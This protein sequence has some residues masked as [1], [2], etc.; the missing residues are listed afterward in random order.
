MTNIHQKM[1]LSIMMLL[2]ILFIPA[3]ADNT[4]IPQFS[5]T[6]GVI[7]L[8][9]VYINNPTVSPDGRY[10]VANVNLVNID[11]R[12]QGKT[13]ILTS[14]LQF[15]WNLSYLWN[16]QG[17]IYLGQ[18]DVLNIDKTPGGPDF[19]FS[20]DSRYIG[21]RNDREVQLYT[22]ADFQL[23]RTQQVTL[24][25]TRFIHG[26]MHFSAWSPD[27]QLLAVLDGETV[28]VWDLAQN[29][30]ERQ[31]VEQAYTTI[32]ATNSGWVIT[33]DTFDKP[34]LASFTV[35]DRHLTMCIPY[36]MPFSAHTLVVSPNGQ[37]VIALAGDVMSS[38]RAVN[39][40]SRDKDD[41]YSITASSL[42]LEIVR[43]LSF[44]PDSQYLLAVSP[45][46]KLKNSQVWDFQTL[47]PVLL[48]APPP[49]SAYVFKSTWLPDSQHL[50]VFGVPPFNTSESFLL[51]LYEIGNSTPID[52]FNLTNILG[53]QDIRKWDVLGSLSDS[54]TMQVSTDGRVVV[55]RM[56]GALLVVP[57]EYG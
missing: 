17:V 28:M 13:D 18:Q 33:D 7:K 2:F 48:L 8:P 26:R 19:S 4:S 53:G 37:T 9:D 1:T 57:I 29:T 52:E 43:P 30:V 42:P 34:A 50:V 31:N 41:T 55:I 21:I 56:G 10:I 15:V 5:G 20:P 44:S 32:I 47:S 12:N 3:K 24:P 54:G 35:C 51:Q 45:D 22:T 36:E 27:S 14:A 38:S 40:W 16:H 6:L 23:A 11:Q 46:N 39:I 49:D 25:L